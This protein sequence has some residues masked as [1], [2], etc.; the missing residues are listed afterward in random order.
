MTQTVLLHYLF[1]PLCGWCYGASETIGAL[2]KHPDIELKPQATGLFAGSGARPM[3]SFAAQAW[4]NDQRIAALSGRQ[5]SDAYRDK[6]LGARDALLDSTVATLAAAAVADTAPKRVIEVLSA[7]QAARYVYG[8]DVTSAAVVA[9]LL[10]NLG[11]VDASAR[12]LSPDAA[13]AEQLRD[14]T[15]KARNLMETYNMQGVPSLIAE[16]DGTSR[17]LDAST[18]YSGPDTVLAALGLA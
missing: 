3:K 14:R 9:S 4:A 6:V 7:I 17:G 13:L 8:K 18:L 1:D 11:L 15:T 5:F 12:V 10:E 2:A 16:V